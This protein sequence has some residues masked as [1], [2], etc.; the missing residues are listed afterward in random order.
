M[1]HGQNET[2]IRV[3][4]DQFWAGRHGAE[5]KTLKAFK[6]WPLEFSSGELTREG[7]KAPLRL[8][9]AATDRCNTNGREFACN[10]LQYIRR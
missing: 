5:T 10:L 2:S 8:P 1:K 3:G 6:N 7:R 4:R 9:V